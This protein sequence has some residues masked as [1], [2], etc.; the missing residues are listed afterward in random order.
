MVESKEVNTAKFAP[1]EADTSLSVENI[2][3]TKKKRKVL[4]TSRKKSLV[5]RDDLVGFTSSESSSS[6]DEEELDGHNSAALLPKTTIEDKVRESPQKTSPLNCE[7]N[8][9]KAGDRIKE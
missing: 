5:K 1:E 6:E 4:I 3:T 7:Q 9:Q 8:V 2:G